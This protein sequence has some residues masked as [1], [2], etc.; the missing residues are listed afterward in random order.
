MGRMYTVEFGPVTGNAADTDFDFFEITPA[1]NKKLTVHAVFVGQ[2]SATGDAEEEM[3]HWKV[4]RGHTSSGG[5]VATTPAPLNPGDPAATFTAESFNG[6]GSIASSGSPIDLHSDT[7]NL[8]VGL[9]FIWTPEMR[10]SVTAGQTRL[11]IRNMTTIATGDQ[12]LH[13][14]LYVEE[15]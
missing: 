10:P 13:G 8:R 11:V 3:L 12:V 14:T 4:I 2:V 7:F 9:A 15:D 1:A 5:G 6:N